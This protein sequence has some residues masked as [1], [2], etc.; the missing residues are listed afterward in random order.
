MSIGREHIALPIRLGAAFE[1][2]SG[3]QLNAPRIYGVLAAPPG[4]TTAVVLMHPASNLMNHYLIDPLAERGIAV[5]ALNS[6]YCGGDSV[7]IMEN[8]IQDLGA[9]VRFLRERG[10]D[11]V[12][13]IGNS[14]GASLMAFYQAQAEHLTIADTPAGDP[15]DLTP[16]ELPPS[17][18]I[19]LLA[20]HPGRSRLMLNYLD[21]A[22]VDEADPDRSDPD[23]D[24]YD[25][26]NGPPFSPEFVARVR[27][28]QRA[29][30]DAITA[31]ARRR[32]AE[33]RSVPGGARDEA[34]VVHRTYADPRF[35][36]LALDPN[37]RKPGGN[38]GATAR[39]ANLSANNLGRFS[40]LT[41]WLS[42]WSMDSRAD[43][44]ANLR[45]TSVPVL[46]VEYSG[47]GGVY[48]SD[49]ALWSEAGG[50][51]VENRVLVGGTHYLAGQPDLLSRVADWVAD[52]S[53]AR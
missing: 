21:A 30:S 39:Q 47:D 25:D 16:D 11:R 48:P 35:L 7:L 43:G 50:A 10:F 22:V 12:V 14:G 13:L 49:V 15:V 26:R 29:R 41:S 45:R 46:Q 4:A 53:K 36:D 18:G 33:L 38:R 3:L 52:W 40:T 19:I 2:Q 23:L 34:F 9:G 44:P 31:R 27:A 32:L 20:G 6:R 28:A 8:V 17:D 42:Q 24:I 51:R 1:S 5:L 37:A